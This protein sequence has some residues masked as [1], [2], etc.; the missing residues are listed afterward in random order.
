MGGSSRE[1]KKRGARRASSGLGAPT[2]R[3]IMQG[4]EKDRAQGYQG[5]RAAAASSRHRGR[6]DGKGGGEDGTSTR[7]PPARGRGAAQAL[8]LPRTIQVGPGRA[9]LGPRTPPGPPAPSPVPPAP[10]ASGGEGV[11][12]RPTRPSNL[13]QV[14]SHASRPFDSQLRS[15]EGP[16]PPR[17]LPPGYIRSQRSRP[18]PG[19]AVRGRRSSWARRAAPLR[20]CAQ[21]LGLDGQRG[22]WRRGAHTPCPLFS[23]HPHPPT[24]LP[25]PQNQG[26]G[27]WVRGSQPSA[28]PLA[29][30]PSHLSLKV[31][32][33]AACP[34]RL[35]QLVPSSGVRPASCAC[36]PL[37]DSSGSAPPGRPAL[38]ALSRCR[39]RRRRSLCPARGRRLRCHRAPRPA[40]GLPLSIRTHF[41][42]RPAEGSTRPPRS[43]PAPLRPSRAYRGA[44]G[45]M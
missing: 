44:R 18:R 21:R 27:A 6:R 12:A 32:P 26:G 40:P 23:R 9:R 28:H 15:R 4:G 5:T 36:R 20:P 43:R 8:P 42:P 14:H 11:G 30:G 3:G 19:P 7:P 24:C 13:L 37:P 1:S 45:E 33:S 29:L 41:P 25:D 31:N 39:R 16:C 34:P 10:T 22:G 17:P 38:P 2:G 35:R